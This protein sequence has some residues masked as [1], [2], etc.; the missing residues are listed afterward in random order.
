MKGPRLTATGVGPSRRVLVSQ[1]EE[2]E[3]SVCGLG[4]WRLSYSSQWT[5]YQLCLV[6][7]EFNVRLSEP[8]LFE[9]T[10][11]TPAACNVALG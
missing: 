7:R 1:V 4:F 10:P 9:G 6:S 8:S 3:G 5:R 2:Q 11:D